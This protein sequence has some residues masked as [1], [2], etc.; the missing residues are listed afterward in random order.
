MK[1]Q[2]AAVAA[3]VAGIPLMTA[4]GAAADPPAYAVV[5]TVNSDAP[6][7][8]VSYFDAAAN[9]QLVSNPPNPWSLTF[10]T[11]PS[12]GTYSYGT[13]SVSGTTTGRQVSCQI[14]VN[15]SVKEQ[16]SAS[17][18]NAHVNCTSLGLPGD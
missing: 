10:T 17:G 4:P 12:G 15:G 13:L 6:L 1:S 3:L 2:R 9:L 11:T 5:Y 16:K 8:D 14:T 18:Q 7:A